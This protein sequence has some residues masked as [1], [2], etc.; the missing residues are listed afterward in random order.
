M[1]AALKKEGTNANCKRAKIEVKFGKNSRNKEVIDL[2]SIDVSELNIDRFVT[3]NT[4]QFL[5]SLFAN[6][7][8]AEDP[9][10][11]L[12]IDPSRWINNEKYLRAEKIV[13]NIIVVNDAAERAINLMTRYNEK[14]TTVEDEK[15]RVLQVVEKHQKLFSYRATKQ[16]I[17]T[18]MQESK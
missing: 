16:K 1:V 9:M 11:F 5:D 3:S 13:E 15:Q 18:S 6:E 2:D 8:N 10:S 17:I 7:S 12:E 4:H 14:I